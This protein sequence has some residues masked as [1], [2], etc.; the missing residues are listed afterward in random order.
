VLTRLTDAGVRTS[1]LV[2]AALL[3]SSSLD[4]ATR[5][6]LI[7]LAGRST[8]ASLPALPEAGGAPILGRVEHAGDWLAFAGASAESLP[9]PEWGAG[10]LEPILVGPAPDLPLPSPVEVTSL[11][12][13][14]GGARLLW[15]GEALDGP[16]K[17]FG[18][19]FWQL[20]K[21]EAS[22]AHVALGKG[23]AAVTY[24]DR[25]LLTPLSL[26]LLR[27][28]VGAMPGARRAAT[29]IMLAPAGRSERRPNAM[30]SAFDDDILRRDVTAA[31]FPNARITLAN[32]KAELPHYRRLEIELADG[33]RVSILLDQGLSGWRTSAFVR[34]DFGKAP[35]AQAREIIAVQVP[36]SAETPRGYP[37]TVGLIGS[38]LAG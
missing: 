18:H 32:R 12:G 17:G 26:A 21:R 11:L 23:A 6:A 30:H 25:Y 3:G 35:A 22:A 10:A 38:P 19:R 13:D 37:A 9:D 33:R 7:R 24:T 1:V 34:H 16:L 4:L 14:L 8:L 20:L 2:P 29:T 5:I 27:E 31:L 28:V 15:L 36:I